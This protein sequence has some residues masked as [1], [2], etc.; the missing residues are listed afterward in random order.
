MVWKPLYKCIKFV[1]R[2]RSTMD[3]AL[4]DGNKKI[5]TIMEEPNDGLYEN[6]NMEEDVAFD[7]EQTVFICIVPKLY[8]Y[9]YYYYYCY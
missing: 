6:R 5:A 3:I 2:R 7:N 4:Q 9:Y 8:Y 1:S